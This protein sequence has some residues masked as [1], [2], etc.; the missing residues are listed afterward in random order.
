MAC[1]DDEGRPKYQVMTFQMI[2]PMTPA[3]TTIWVRFSALA[4]P[5]PMVL[6]TLVNAIA[7]AKLR[8]AAIMMAAFTESA[9]VE[10]LVAMALAVSWKPL[11]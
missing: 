4:I 10:T 6:A 8:V 9:R 11:M 7:P 2:A 5:V 1:D 3:R